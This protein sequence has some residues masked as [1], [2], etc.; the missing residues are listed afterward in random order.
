MSYGALT[1]EK[2]AEQFIRTG[3]L[4]LEKE[5][6]II[7]Y[8]DGFASILKD[9]DF[10]NEILHFNKEK[11]ENYINKKSLENYDLYGK[12][13]TMVLIKND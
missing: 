10:I 7:F 4:P 9:N 12:E 2:E 11:I 6:I 13:K 1:G 8:S 5:D 3:T